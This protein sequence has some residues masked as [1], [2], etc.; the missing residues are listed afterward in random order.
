MVFFSF[1]VVVVVVVVIIF[2]TYKTIVLLNT[3]R[4]PSTVHIFSS[5]V[6]LI[7]SAN[8]NKIVPGA[9]SRSFSM[10]I[11]EAELEYANVTGLEELRV[12]VADYYNHLYRQGK[13]SQYGPENICVVPGGRAGLTR[14]MA[15]LG[16][17][18]IFL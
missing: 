4:Y 7:K 14:I 3:V 8:Q 16:N 2:V 5:V 11:P 15:V 13:T 1:V 9:P 10:T 6:L 17:V 18:R 12:K